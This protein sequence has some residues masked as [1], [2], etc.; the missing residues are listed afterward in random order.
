MPHDLEGFDAVIERLT[1]DASLYFGAAAVSIRPGRPEDRPYSRLLRADVDAGATSFG[2]FVKILK[3]PG[4]TKVERTRQRLRDDFAATRQVHDAL[5]DDSLAGAVSPVAVFPDHLALVT[6]EVPGSNLLRLI[7]RAA[8]FRAR[9]SQRSLLVEAL[10]N[11]GRWL[12]V[13]QGIPHIASGGPVLISLDDLTAYIDHRLERLVAAPRARF[14]L[15]DRGAV[16][17]HI[18]N[19]RKCVDATELQDVPMHSDLAPANIM[20]SGNRIVVIDF[21]MVSRGGRYHDLAR[22]FAQMDLLKRK[23]YLRSGFID[24]LQ[25]GLL[26]GYRPDL[27]ASHPLFKLH[28]LLHTVNHFATLSLKPDA[29]PTSFY[30]WWVRS[31]HRRWLQQAATG[32]GIPVN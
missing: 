10:S 27:E 24:A 8:S 15:R 26:R 7:E 25:R 21:A 22:L 13:F 5:K 28:L 19:L 29:F 2:I 12:R 6:R 18:A 3:T 1:H 17:D 4:P 20:V 9:D 23:P 11:V 30:N 31:H 14:S 16:L 32:A